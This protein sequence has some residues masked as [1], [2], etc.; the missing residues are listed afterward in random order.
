MPGERVELIDGLLLVAEPQSSAHFSAVRLAE[1]DRQPGRRVL[2]VRRD[3]APSPS[4][5][6]GWDDRDVAVLGPRDG[7]RPLAAPAASIAVADLLP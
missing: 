3:P 2:E 6:Y 4:A 1:L 7:A 5:A